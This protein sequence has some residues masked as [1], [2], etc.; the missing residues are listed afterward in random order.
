MLTLET[1]RLTLRPWRNSDRAPFAAINADAEVRQYYYPSLLAAEE[2][3]ELIDE[4]AKQLAREGFGFLAVERKAD[5][6]L[7]GGAGLSRPGSEVPG[8]F[9]LEIGWILG[10]A[11]WR[12]GYATEVGR[13][14]LEFAWR[15]QAECVIGY[16]SFINHPSR[17]AMEKLG[18]IYVEGG[19]FDDITVPPGHVMRPHVL[20]RIDRPTR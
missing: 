20:Y 19:D 18:M 9:P 10:R 6:A 4:A 8:N 13:R 16:T 3:D 17:R 2:T 11:Y 7:I 15:L 14:C 1:S 12:Q 5:G